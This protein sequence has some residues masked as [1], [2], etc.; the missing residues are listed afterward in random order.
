MS[1]RGERIVCRNCKEKIAVEDEN[2]PHCGTSIRSDTAYIVAIVF[3]VVLLGAALFDPG[4]LL[5]YGAFGLLVAVVAGYVLYE[6][7]QRIRQASG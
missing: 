7:R 4:N 5:A 2:C 1:G 6:K 3:G